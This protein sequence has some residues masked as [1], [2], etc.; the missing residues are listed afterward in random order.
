[1]PEERPKL[2]SRPEAPWGMWAGIAGGLAAAALSVKGIV[3]SGSSAAAIGFIFVPFVAIAAM[4]PSAVWGLALGCV[5]LSLR[6]A[7]RYAPAMLVAAWALA[8]AGPAV[9][10]WE[11]WRGLELE[12]AVRE[13][14]TLDA[15]ALE[16]TLER[17]PWNRDKF[18]L[19][20]I[21]LRKDAGPALLDRIAALDD[22]ELFEPMGSLWDVM[23]ENRKGI[24]VMRLLANHGNARGETLARLAAGPHA[25][26]L[27]HELARNPNTPMDI[28]KRWF[29]STDY[30]VEWGLALNPNTPPAVMERLSR[31]ENLYTRMN[32]TY[33][34]ATPAPILQRLAS[35]PDELLAR[36][37]RL[38]LERRRGSSLILHPSSLVC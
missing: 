7:Q 2:S 29:D 25:D 36:N 33:N 21:V 19:G 20:A 30:L 28:L 34:A 18:Y 23:G 6:G 27:R 31:S 15:R 26:K 14:R 38:A 3:A 1:M 5:W 17:S 12:R 35:D 37:A 13:V 9:I 24:A 32:L 8:L 4:L 22:S 16:A 11:V 10:G